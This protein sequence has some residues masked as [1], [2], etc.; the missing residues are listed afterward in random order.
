M[1]KNEAG[2]ITFLLKQSNADEIS[3]EIKY[4]LNL[5]SSFVVMGDIF[6]ITPLNNML[7][8]GKM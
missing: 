8:L 2:A 6:F 4:L 3:D 1:L 5:V 7:R